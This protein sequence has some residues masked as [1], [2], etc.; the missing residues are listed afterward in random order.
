MAGKVSKGIDLNS[1]TGA[2]FSFQK[3][4]GEENLFQYITSDIAGT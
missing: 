3:A 1:D 2:C 4:P